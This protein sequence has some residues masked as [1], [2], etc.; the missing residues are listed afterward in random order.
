MDWRFTVRRK[1]PDSDSDNSVG[2]YYKTHWKIE[3]AQ[4]L[5]DEAWILCSECDLA[6]FELSLP[7]PDREEHKSDLFRAGPNERMW[8]RIDYEVAPSDENWRPTHKKLLANELGYVQTFKSPGRVWK[9]VVENLS[10]FTGN[11]LQD[12]YHTDVV[13][14]LER[15]ALQLL[16]Q[17]KNRGG[18]V[19]VGD[20]RTFLYREPGVELKDANLSNPPRSISSP[21]LQQYTLPIGCTPDV[22]VWL[23]LPTIPRLLRLESQRSYDVIEF[24]FGTDFEPSVVSDNYEIKAPTKYANPLYTWIL[25]GGFFLAILSLTLSI[26]GIVLALRAINP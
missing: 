10:N 11:K 14:R 7:D 22:R 16:E 25:W 17:F 19:Q 23:P 1:L 3:V 13:A 18:S 26:I 20:W 9:D 21:Q 24:F 4:G 2:G 12:K 15:A 6:I 5:S 8:L